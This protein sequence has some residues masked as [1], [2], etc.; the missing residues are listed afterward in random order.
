VALRE[1]GPSTG[2]ESSATIRARVEAARAIQ[3]RRYAHATH[4][5]SNACASGRAMLVSLAP[6]ARVMLDH[7]AESLSLSARA[8]HRV[9]KVARTI[10]DLAQEDGIGA[11]QIGEALRYRP[12]GAGLRAPEGLRELSR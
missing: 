5:Q 11:V 10:A 9:V 12:V 4:G 1:L 7:A 2:G 8:Y 6:E 3:R